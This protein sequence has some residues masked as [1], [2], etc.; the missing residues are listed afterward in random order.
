MILR[1]SKGLFLFEVKP[2]NM[3]EEWSRSKY[4]NI[5]DYYP[6]AVWLDLAKF[7]HFGKN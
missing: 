4:I 7:H 6:S 5:S 1:H 2:L 3:I